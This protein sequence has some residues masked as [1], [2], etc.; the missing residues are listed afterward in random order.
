MSADGFELRTFD[1]VPEPAV[2]GA[3]LGYRPYRA[4]DR[5]VV[6]SQCDLRGR[7]GYVTETT[8]K[9]SDAETKGPRVMVDLDGVDGG[10]WG[11]Y[12]DELELLDLVSRIGELHGAG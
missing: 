8:T 12:E 5:V 4:G 2:W 3:W 6:R 9:Y 11:F 7:R 1:L 10:S